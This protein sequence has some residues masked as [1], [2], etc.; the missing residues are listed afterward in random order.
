MRASLDMKG[1]RYYVGDTRFEAV[2]IFSLVTQ[3][4]GWVNREE[5]KKKFSLKMDNCDTPPVRVIPLI[6]LQILEVGD[7]EQV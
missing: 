7:S 4:P 2:T 5:I 1:K 6:D 3:P